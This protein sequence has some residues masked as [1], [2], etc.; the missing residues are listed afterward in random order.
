MTQPKFIF[1][2]NQQ[3]LFISAPPIMQ[4]IIVPTKSYDGGS[5]SSFEARRKIFQ[6]KNKEHHEFDAF[7]YYSSQDNRMRMLHGCQQEEAISPPETVSE[8][9]DD[10]TTTRRGCRR[11]ASSSSSVETHARPTRRTRISFEMHPSLILMYAL[12]LHDDN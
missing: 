3:L 6:A 2:A 1:F 8:G 11:G 4:T 12:Q 7:S 10:E 9:A 5:T